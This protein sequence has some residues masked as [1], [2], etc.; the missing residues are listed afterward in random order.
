MKDRKLRVCFAASSGGHLDEL[1]M[2]RPLMDRYDSFLVTERPPTGRLRGT[3]GVTG[4][5][6]STA[7]NIPASPGCWSMG[8]APWASS[9]RNARTW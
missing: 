1:M 7:G 2:L 9:W 3:S 5:C 6:K 4:S 8:S